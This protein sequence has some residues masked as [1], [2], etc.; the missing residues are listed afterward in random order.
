MAI[1]SQ[2]WR[3]IKLNSLFF[4]WFFFFL[5]FGAD[6]G[7]DKFIASMSLGIITHNNVAIRVWM[8]EPRCWTNFRVNIFFFWFLL[9]FLLTGATENTEKLFIYFIFSITTFLSICSV[10]FFYKP[11]SVGEFQLNLFILWL[12]LLFICLSFPSSMWALFSSLFIG[13]L[14]YTAIAYVLW[15]M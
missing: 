12:I 15:K 9:L 2:G 11:K 8:Y 10:I 1:V 6:Y 4:W 5:Y 14:T 7:W 3:A 13:I